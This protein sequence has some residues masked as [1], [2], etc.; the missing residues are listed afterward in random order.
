LT[1]NVWAPSEGEANKAV[2]I[3]IYGGGYTTGSTQIPLY[4]GQHLA[5][6]QDVIVVSIKYAVLFLH[7]CI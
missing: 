3:W 2:M 1:L 4:D 6:N 7:F 5:A